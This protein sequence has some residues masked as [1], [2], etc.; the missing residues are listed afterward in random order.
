MDSVVSGSDGWL[1][2]T[3]TLKD[4]LG[5]DRFS[6]RELYNIAH[7]LSLAYDYV[8]GKG[9][10]F[11]L[12]VPANKNTLYGD[13][14]P[15]YDS[16][17]VDKTHNIEALTPLIEKMQIPYA[18]LVKSFK[19]E[20]EV[21]YLKTDSHWN[22]KGAV[23]AY[24]TIMDALGLAHDDY[25][26]AEVR[27]TKDDSGDLGRMMYTFYGPEEENYIYN[28][29]QNFEYSDKFQSV[30]DS[31]IETSGTGENGR[32]L[33]YRDSFGNTLIPVIANEFSDCFFSKAN[34]YTLERQMEEN[35]PDTVIF[36]KVERNLG[37]FMT[38]PPVISAPV[39]EDAGGLYEG[40][41]QEK[42]DSGTVIKSLDADVDY[43]VISGEVDRE[44]LEND[45]D[46]LVEVNG[47]TYEAYHTGENSF[48]IYL[49]KE[50][51]TFPADVKVLV[52]GDPIKP[53]EAKTF[54]SEV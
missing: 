45:T 41:I 46:I 24:N 6:E 37:E 7:N 51:V 23:L 29:Q 34:Q 4:Y 47:T 49:K 52:K 50:N 9:S 12:T 43:Y 17:I 42:A 25:S 36:E 33:M 1:Y 30:E 27:V 14:M 44:L 22:N 28:I 53:V 48:C 15:Y 16:Y 18:D 39:Y 3:S 10:S 13:N 38:M 8:R 20:D 19:D 26:G 40:E 54:N 21:L 32:L 2:Y 11:V 31:R 35:D 5:T